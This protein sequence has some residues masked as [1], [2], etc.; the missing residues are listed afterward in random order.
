MKRQAEMVRWDGKMIKFHTWID[1]QEFYEIRWK[2]YLGITVALITAIPRNKLLPTEPG[3]Y[4]KYT[5]PV[6]LNKL[7]S[8]NLLDE[9]H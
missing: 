5:G 7:T 4:R 8:A 9:L 2:L 1:N 6:L 3:P